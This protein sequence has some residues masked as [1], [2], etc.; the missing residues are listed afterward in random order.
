MTIATIYLNIKDYVRKTAWSSTTPVQ[1]YQNGK[2]QNHNKHHKQESRDNPF[3][4]L[5]SE[6]C[7]N[8][9]NFHMRK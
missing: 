8:V 1:R 6:N 9:E 3:I 2:K 7:S 4:R 5:C